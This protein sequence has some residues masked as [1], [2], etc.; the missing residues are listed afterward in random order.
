[1]PDMNNSIRSVLVA[2]DFS[3][4]A[5]NAASRA[6]LLAGEHGASLKLLHVV[7]EDLLS[8]LRGRL[9]VQ[10][11]TTERLVDGA[12]LDLDALA[13]QLR[14]AARA[15]PECIL[16]T[17]NVLDEILAAAD[18]ADVLVLGAHGLHPT[19]D[20]LIGTTAERLLRKSR[21]PMLVVRKEARAT[22]QRVFVAVD[23]SVHSLAAFRFALQVAPSAHVHLFHAYTCPYEGKLRQANLSDET[24][25]QL[26]TEYRDQAL[27]NMQNMLEKTAAPL[28]RTSSAVAHGN[29][30]FAASTCAAEWGADLI[31]L[32][33][34]GYSLIG[35]LFLGGVT[36]HT[37]SRA[38]C[39][40]AVVPDFKR[41]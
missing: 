5:A 15:A 18:H 10:S 4:D 2:S 28:E 36:R 17:G 35:E 41:L 23:F 8:E 29:A 20:L 19:Q 25:G 12:K 26:R 14:P 31:V 32:G 33:K 30:R 9:G 21:R 39:D 34:H 40:V 6:A 27:A 11:D 7:R 24:I 22:Y 3:I 1:M 37:V 38:K 13:A 16:R